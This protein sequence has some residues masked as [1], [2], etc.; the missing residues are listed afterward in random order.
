VTTPHHGETEAPPQGLDQ[1]LEEAFERLGEYGRE[2]V[3]GLIVFAV[4][5]S[6]LAGAWEWNRRQA[7]QQQRALSEVE[8]A[9]NRGLGANPRAV[10]PAEPANSEQALAARGQ[11]LAA[12]D[13][14]ASEYAGSIAGQLAT[15]RAAELEIDLGRRTAAIERLRALVPTLDADSVVRAVAL[16]LQGYALEAGESYAEAAEAYAS[17]G[18]IDVYPDRPAVWLSAA[19]NY[20]RVGDTDG[21]T[22]AYQNMLQLDPVFA[23]KQGVAEHLNRLAGQAAA[24]PP[25]SE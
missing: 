22:I 15:L 21:Q 11:A 24:E 9:L 16:R 20:A 2:I 19:N 3:I 4:V 13:A 8:I 7:E 18:A 25:A 17:A 5:G 23:E 14:L 1:R 6:A 12:F 10:F